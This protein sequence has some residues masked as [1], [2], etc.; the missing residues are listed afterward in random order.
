MVS[1]AANLEMG[2]GWVIVDD[3]GRSHNKKQREAFNQNGK[4]APHPTKG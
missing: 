2:H 1:L 4:K 3:G